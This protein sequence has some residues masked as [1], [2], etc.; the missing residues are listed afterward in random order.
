M[1]LYTVTIEDRQY[2]VSISGNHCTVDGEAVQARVVPLNPNGL[3]LLRDGRQAH[4]LFLTTQDGDTY[5]MFMF[6]GRRIVTRIT[7]PARQH[8]QPSGAED[9]GK[10]LCAPMHGLVVDVPARLG[11]EVEK[12]QTLVV[13][14]SMKMQ[15]QLRSPRGGKVSKISAQ[16][17]SQ[18]EKGTILVEFE[19]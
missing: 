15:R 11:Q 13:L 2:K 7:D 14:E 4:E 18:V 9:S 3:Q 5:E 12:G 19:D 1:S 16:A 17:G 6:G 10:A 8:A